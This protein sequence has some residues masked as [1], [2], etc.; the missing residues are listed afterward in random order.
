MAVIRGA[1]GPLL[2]KT[3]KEQLA[4]EHD[5]LEGKKDRVPVSCAKLRGDGIS[6]CAG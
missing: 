3:I 5:V 2:E 1:L 4:H 6:W